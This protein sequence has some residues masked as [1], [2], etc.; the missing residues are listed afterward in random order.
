MEDVQTVLNRTLVSLRESLQ[1]SIDALNK[2]KSIRSHITDDPRADGIVAQMHKLNDLAYEVGLPDAH[3]HTDN[4]T[5][6]AGM[7]DIVSMLMANLQPMQPSNG[8]QNTQSQTNGRDIFGMFQLP[9]L[10]PVPQVPSLFPMVPTF[11]ST[12]TIRRQFHIPP[13]RAQQ[14][15]AASQQNPPTTENTQPVAP[16]T[17]SNPL[18]SMIASML[19]SMVGSNNGPS[20]TPG[21]PGTSGSENNNV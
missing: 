7:G 5:L 1:T 15:T 3:T 13:R 17:G 9:G 11:D 16:N 19:S 14:T 2:I 21:T 20:Q 8:S 10:P 6:D 4:V 18:E 12:T